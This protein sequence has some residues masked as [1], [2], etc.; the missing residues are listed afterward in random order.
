MS[1]LKIYL[2]GRFG[3]R[4]Q[5]KAV[6]QA[7]WIAGHTV[8]SRWLDTEWER[9][10]EKESSVAP[11]E[12]RAKYA[13]IDMEDL[14][15]ADVVISFTEEPDSLS[16]KRGGRHVEFGIA[17]QAGKRLIVVG[18]RENIFHHLPQVEF[19]ASVHA[20]MYNAFGITFDYP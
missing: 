2:A 12:Y 7:L 10:S 3:R 1:S 18:W 5:L 4:E 13:L 14:L 11:P 15:A 9:T 8:T 19:H 20:M 16:G 6:R 17:A